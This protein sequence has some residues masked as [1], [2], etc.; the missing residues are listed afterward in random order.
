MV[1]MHRPA[2]LLL[3]FAWPAL[4]AAAPRWF[5]LELLVFARE[6]VPQGSELWSQEPGLPDLDAAQPTPG[7]SAPLRLTAAA[8]RLRRQPG[9][10]V[11]LHTAWR[12]PT[13]GRQ[14][15][16][17]VR[18]TDAGGAEATLDGMVR[19]SVQRYLHLDLDLV[20]T[21][22]LALPVSA[23][24]SGTVA[25]PLAEPAVTAAPAVATTPIWRRQPFRLVDSRRMRSDEVHYI[26]H[27]A[28]GVL[29]LAT[30]YQPPV[31]AAP[32]EA[33]AAPEGTAA[34][35][36]TST[37]GVTAEP[38]TPA[39]PATTPGTTNPPR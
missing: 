36:D 2:L 23:P 34:A 21:R 16:P 3:L 39:A 22:E 30:V 25:I 17:W 33:A 10:R 27:P 6:A 35:D 31:P 7:S 4:T 20:V 13:A 19:L 5:D 29:A 9:H 11:L 8:D 14:S 32:R 28:F 38:A 1:A 24:V 15:T 12:Q 18:L 37:T 26:D